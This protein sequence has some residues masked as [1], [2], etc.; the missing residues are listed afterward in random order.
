VKS[1]AQTELTLEIKGEKFTGFESGL[2]FTATESFRGPR[3]KYDNVWVFDKDKSS[4][5]NSGR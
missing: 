1:G 4:G 3:F 2:T 5:E